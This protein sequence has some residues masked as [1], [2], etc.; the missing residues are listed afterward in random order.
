MLIVVTLTVVCIEYLLILR[1]VAASKT[2]VG[3][4][5]IRRL[6]VFG[7]SVSQNNRIEKVNSFN[8]KYGEIITLIR[9]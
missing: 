3:K 4:Q 6:K 5:N 7:S 1:W 8:R 2:N 9:F